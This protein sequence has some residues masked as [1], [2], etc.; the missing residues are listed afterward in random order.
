MS[1]A[2][3]VTACPSCR[4]GGLVGFGWQRAKE[5]GETSAYV[6][7]RPMRYGSLYQCRDCGHPWYLDSDEKLMNFIPADRIALCE[8]WDAGPIRF[9]AAHLARLREIGAT[10]YGSLSVYR[11]TPCCV[12]T[13]KGER[14][15]VAI[16]SE[17]NHPPYESWPRQFRFATEIADIEESSYALPFDVRKATAEAKEMRMGFAPTAVQGPDKRTFLLNETNNFY[18]GSHGPA[19]DIRLVGMSGINWNHMPKVYNFEKPVV[20]FVADK[21]Q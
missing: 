4:P 17:R 21:E 18:D 7:K 3:P 2:A 14:F 10:P 12:V 11:D 9:D 8:E 1:E 15:D 6:L 13:K 5:K 16:V 20:Y 19:K